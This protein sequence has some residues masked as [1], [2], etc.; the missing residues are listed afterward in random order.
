MLLILDCLDVDYD[1]RLI[2]LSQIL[3]I[4]YIRKAMFIYFEFLNMHKVFLPNIYIY[5]FFFFLKGGI[6]CGSQVAWMLWC[7]FAWSHQSIKEVGWFRQRAQ[8]WIEVPNPP[9]T[10]SEQVSVC[11]SLRGHNLILC[12]LYSLGLLWRKS[13]NCV[14][15]MCSHIR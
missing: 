1:Y 7:W 3:G 11:W 4:S 9:L 8:P 5:I 13:N 10:N 12:P 14:Y 15:S 2:F 6:Y